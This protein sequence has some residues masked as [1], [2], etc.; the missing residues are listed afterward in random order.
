MWCVTA[1]KEQ[2][3]NENCRGASLIGTFKYFKWPEIIEDL[4][5]YIRVYSFK[6]SGKSINSYN[7]HYITL[8]GY[9][10]HMVVTVIELKGQRR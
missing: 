5:L 1:L 10:W 4:G 8:L 2:E 6:S 3:S 9:F 7:T